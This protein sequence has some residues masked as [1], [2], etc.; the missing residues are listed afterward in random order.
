MTTG[1]KVGII[2]GSIGLLIGGIVLYK[3]YKDRQALANGTDGSGDTSGDQINYQ[4]VDPT[5]INARQ[6]T[7]G[8]D[9]RI[10]SFNQANV[11]LKGGS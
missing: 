11:H 7:F 8:T 6:G 9:T 1:A 3:K 10:A 5:V 2:V 4:Q